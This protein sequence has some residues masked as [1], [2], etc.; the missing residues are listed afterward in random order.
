MFKTLFTSSPRR[1]RLICWALNCLTVAIALPYS[2]HDIPRSNKVD[3]ETIAVTSENHVTRITMNRP[4]VLNSIN[5]NMHDELQHVFDAFAN[6][7][8]QY[9]GVLN[10]AGDRAFCA[11]R[12]ICSP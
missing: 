8:N 10:G 7:D 5:Q 4:E 1:G 12:P 2:M 9:V 3:Y 11:G 6:D